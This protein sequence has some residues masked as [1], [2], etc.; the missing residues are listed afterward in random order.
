MKKSY[1]AI[2]LIV[3]IAIFYFLFGCISLNS[4]KQD[5]DGKTGEVWNSVD[6]AIQV[7]DR[8]EGQME[9]YLADRQDLID[10]ITA[11][12]NDILAAK[13]NGDLR[14]LTDAQNKTEIAVQAIAE[15]YPDI[16]L[17][18][19]QQGLMDE[20]AGS[21]NRIAYARK[22]LIEVQVRYNQSTIL[23]PFYPKVEVLGSSFNPETTM[24][25]STFGN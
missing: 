10:Q 21:I 12:R 17:S 23:F 14:A 3:F 22:E 8:L 18:G 13:Q 5:I 1:I 15:A 7:L 16:S 2:A 24:P 9:V 4:L 25:P 19:L 20:T 11:G 6:R